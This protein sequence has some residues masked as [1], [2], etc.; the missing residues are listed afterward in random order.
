MVQND[1]RQ[2]N[3]LQSDG[4]GVLNSDN[5]N[6]QQSHSPNHLSCWQ[7]D[8]SWKG[9][10]NGD[11]LSLRSGSDRYGNSWHDRHS[12]RQNTGDGQQTFNTIVK[13]PVAAVVEA[14]TAARGI[15]QRNEMLKRIAV[16]GDELLAA[17]AAVASAYNQG[18]AWPARSDLYQALLPQLTS[19]EEV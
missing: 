8:R 18:P 17:P 4:S 6:S 19:L 10:R 1:K 9:E 15:V 3:S 14:V 13:D 5:N 16:L 2:R 7:L 11:Q 12:K